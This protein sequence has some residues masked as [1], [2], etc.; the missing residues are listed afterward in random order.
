[1]KFFEDSRKLWTALIGVLCGLS[2]MSTAGAAYNANLTGTVTYLS[3]YEGG[4][5]LFELSSQPASNGSCTHTQFEI[6]PANNTDAA[7]GRMY[8]RLLLAYSTQQPLNVGFDNAGSCG[9]DGYIHVYE[10]G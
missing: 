6:D 4:V 7:L 8:A 2:I 10:V 3:T 9:T 5:V 1:M